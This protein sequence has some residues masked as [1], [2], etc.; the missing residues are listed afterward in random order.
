MTVV[1]EQDKND[2]ELSILLSRLIVNG[3]SY[4]IFTIGAELDPVISVK[5]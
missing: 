1:E 5:F 2:K 3:N 4:P